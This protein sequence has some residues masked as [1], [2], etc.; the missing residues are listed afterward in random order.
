[1]FLLIGMMLFHPVWAVDISFQ[2]SALASLG[3]IL[4]SR[5]PKVQYVP[6]EQG[7]SWRFAVKQIWVWMQKE[8][9]TTLS[10]QVLT[11]PLILFTFGRISLI[12]PLTNIL[13]GWTIPII[14]VLGLLLCVF[15]LFIPSLS[16]IIGWITWVF[17]EFTIRVIL[18]TGNIPFVSIGR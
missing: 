10:A 13:I 11:L 5:Q 6:N 12:S 16:Y 2:L 15:G 7:K 8:L 18:W 14:T 4:F 9:T 1:M 17:L 3:M